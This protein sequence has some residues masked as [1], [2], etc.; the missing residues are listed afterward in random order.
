MDNGI[1][2]GAV[3]SEILITDG[4]AISPLGECPK[5]GDGDNA[6]YDITIQGGVARDVTC[7]IMLGAHEWVPN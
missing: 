2:D 1:I 5:S 3:G 7:L 6:D 4:Y